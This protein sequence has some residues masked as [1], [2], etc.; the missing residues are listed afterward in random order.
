MNKK[1]R[2]ISL[3]CGCGGFDLGM[4]IDEFECIGA[5]DIN[6]L[7]VSVYN[8]NIA[9]VA[10]VFDL[11]RD[12]NFKH[13]DLDVILSGAPCQGFSTA[14]KRNLHD[15][16]NSLFLRAV[17][18]V[19]QQEPK[20]FIAENVSG[21]LSGQHKIKYMD[22]AISLLESSGYKTSLSVVDCRNLGMAQMRKRAILIAWNTG[23]KFNLPDPVGRPMTIREAIGD[24][25]GGIDNHEPSTCRAIGVQSVIAKRIRPGQKLSNVRSGKRS[26]HTWDIPEVYGKTCKKERDVLEAIL[27]IRRKERI[28]DWGDADPVS[29]ESL[30]QYLGYDPIKTVCKL[31]EKGFIKN[32]DEKIDLTNTFNG[33]YRRLCWDEQSL[34]VD[35]RFGSPILFLHPTEDRAYTVREA[36]RL[37]GFPDCFTFE[38]PLKAQYE[39]VGNA[40]P[41]PLA[42]F[43]CRCI[44]NLLS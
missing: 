21:I 18:I 3:F 41:P 22:V 44:V 32:K 16:R 35:T 31:K 4:E 2:Y 15:P 27:R 38:G 43:I 29:L 24:I 28:R 17:E 33:K 30:K 39:M 8:K 36:A 20:V 25:S 10:Q 23:K 6:K 12:F 34:T 5:F 1:Y 11:S 7:V 42:A 37:Q 13:S 40:V 9:N 14:G 26:V 19:L